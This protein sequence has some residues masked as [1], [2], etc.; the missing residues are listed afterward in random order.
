M[1]IA[2][3]L[4]TDNI[5][6][7]LDNRF[8]RAEYYGIVDSETGKAVEVFENTAKQEPSGAG[9]SAVQLLVNKGAEA[10]I[11]PEFGPKAFDALNRFSVKLFKQGDHK[12]ITA[13]LEAWKDG[14]L[15]TPAAPGRG[16]LHKA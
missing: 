3:C 4:K 14:K 2:F 16:G 9:A 11:A 6:S 5:D 15:D 8:G 10:V 12:K 7:E 13:A 1:K